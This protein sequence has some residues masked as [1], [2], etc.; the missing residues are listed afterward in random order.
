MADVRQK[1]KFNKESF[2]PDNSPTAKFPLAIQSHEKN[3]TVLETKISKVLRFKHESIPQIELSEKAKFSIE[4]MLKQK[5]STNPFQSLQSKGKS[6]VSKP[7]CNLV[8]RE[9]TKS[10]INIREIQN[11]IRSRGI[12]ISNI[13]TYR[14]QQKMNEITISG[15]LA[16]KLN[17]P[18]YNQLKAS[19]NIGFLLK[20]NTFQNYA[21]TSFAFPIGRK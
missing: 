17:S 10:E 13:L 20:T 15:L 5:K 7:Q 18:S 19:D 3:T 2:E 9:K 14:S 21:K 12:T 11:R 1:N 16:S 6:G 8:P 4:D